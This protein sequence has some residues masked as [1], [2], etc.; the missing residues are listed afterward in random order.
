[1]LW[2]GDAHG[3]VWFRHKK[4]LIMAGKRSCFGLSATNQLKNGPDISSKTSHYVAANLAEKCPNI[5]TQIQVVAA[6]VAVKCPSFQLLGFVSTYMAGH[7]LSVSLNISNY[8][9]T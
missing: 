2:Q 7:Y 6:N 8:V 5:L 1:M 4:H 9:A 3:L